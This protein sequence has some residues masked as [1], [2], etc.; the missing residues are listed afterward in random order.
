MNPT[1]PSTSTDTSRRRFLQTTAATGTLAGVVGLG[2]VTTARAQESPAEIRLGG[3]LDGW[4]GRAPESIAGE[5]NP[6]LRLEVGTRYRITWENL[7]GLGHN[8]ALL[9]G[10]GAAIERT[11]VMSEKGATQTLE[12]TATEEMVTYV[13]EPHSSVMRGDVSFSDGSATTT[14]TPEPDADQRR[15]VPLGGSVRIEPVVE[16]LV[17][18]LCFEV[19]PE[20]T[21]RYF[22]VDRMGRVYVAD[23]DGLRDEPFIDVSGMLAEIGGEKGLLGMAF[24]PDFQ[25]NRRFFLRFSAP[26]REGTPEN[27]SHTE[28][29]TE[30]E[31]SED[32]ERG[33]PDTARTILE[34]PSPYDT[35]N[36]GSIVFG[37]DGYLFV[38]MGDGGRAHDTGR[39]HVQ[40]WYE[41]NEG[42]NGQD[43]TENLLGSILR[44]DVDSREGGKPYA[45]P[46]DAFL[47]GRPGLNEQFAWGFRNPWGMSFDD[48]G[49]LFVADVGQNGFEEVNIVEQ[50]RNYGWNVREGTHCFRP[51]PEESR[52]PP[53]ECPTKLPP[54]VRGGERLIPP[55]IEYP[56][57]HEGVG[58]G[59]AVVGGYVYA[60]DAIS[61][62]TGKYV[63]GD[64]RKTKD[65][66]VPTGSLF[67][68]TPSD[69][70]RLWSMEEISIENTDSGLLDAYVLAMGEDNQGRLYVLTTG[71]P[72]DG[73]SGAVHRILPPEESTPTT[74]AT[75]ET[76]TNATD[77]G[78]PTETGTP[79]P[80]TT[81]TDQEAPGFGV[82]AAL[83]AL[84][85]GVARLLRTGDED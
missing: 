41:A 28:V 51:G 48:E 17:A 60:N 34:V 23:S 82:L 66:D 13:C 27:F 11:E 85:L 3:T 47:R 16:G 20:E 52:N 24:H 84:S 44:I 43:I 26:R 33:L 2:G 40:D 29:L 6:T 68:A 53:A 70:D 35:H 67:A 72:G 22:I 64:F 65:T 46:D 36:A 77:S 49:R 56:H 78:S 42:G 83:S 18:P 31:A 7:D 55:I 76:T 81:I 59:S 58:V 14:T 71:S 50:D 19:P 15:Y 30:F 75:T 45:I 37:P 63:F 39:G 57:S 9:D 1:R 10:G 5:T 61:H 80:G 25:E 62:L 32:L 79:E 73:Q 69:D 4:Q 38:A 12:F 21:G 54:D 8:I 74:T